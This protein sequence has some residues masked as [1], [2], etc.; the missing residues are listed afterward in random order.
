MEPV[1]EHRVALV[2]GAEVQHVPLDLEEVV[3]VEPLEE[4]LLELGDLAGRCGQ[5]SFYASQLMEYAPGSGGN[6]RFM[7][8]SI[9]A[10]RSVRIAQ[11]RS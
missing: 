7:C 6:Q 4:D 5:L 2:R 8:C 1:D 11:A 3:Q 9:W 10:Y